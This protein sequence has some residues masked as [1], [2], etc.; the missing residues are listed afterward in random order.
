MSSHY[1][2]ELGDRSAISALKR[3]IRARVGGKYYK[4]IFTERESTKQL[5]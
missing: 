4:I 3:A 5:L 2:A 1:S